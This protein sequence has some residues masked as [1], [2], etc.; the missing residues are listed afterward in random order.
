MQKVRGAVL[1]LLGRDCAAVD[2]AARESKA[3]A[4]GVSRA[5]LSLGDPAV[6]LRKVGGGDDRPNAR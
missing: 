5:A 4:E 6:V 3:A 1:V 2:A